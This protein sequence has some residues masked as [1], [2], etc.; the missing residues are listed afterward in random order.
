[1]KNFWLSWFHHK[2]M[3]G[4]GLAFPSWVSGESPW[5]KTICAAIK[6]TGE[7]E[8]WEIVEKS[9]AERPVV[10]ARRFCNEQEEGWSPFN[11]RFPKADW[12]TWE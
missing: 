4:Y 3:S 2:S 10:L 9:Y 12:M 11:D 8:A 1:M 7:E 5:G 6:A